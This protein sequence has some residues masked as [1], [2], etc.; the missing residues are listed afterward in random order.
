M[1]PLVTRTPTGQWLADDHGGSGWGRHAASRE[2]AYRIVGMAWHDR[3]RRRARWAART[4]RWAEVA[5]TV[6]AWA[7]LALTPAMAVLLVCC[8]VAL[9]DGGASS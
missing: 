2:D 8:V 3:A 6:A 5:R 4:E 7:A 1:G 9:Y